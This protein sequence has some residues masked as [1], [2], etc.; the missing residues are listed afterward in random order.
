MTLN[1]TNVTICENQS[2]TFAAGT[3]STTNTSSINWTRN[4]DGNFD[5]TDIENPTYTPGPGDIINGTVNVIFNLLI[6]SDK[7]LQMILCSCGIEQGNNRQITVRKQ[8]LSEL[9]IQRNKP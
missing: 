8:T 9:Q 2:Y 4:G 5:F 6:L 3:V 7:E 1:P